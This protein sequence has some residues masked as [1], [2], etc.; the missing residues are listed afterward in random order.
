MKKFLVLYFATMSAKEQTMK[1]DP[2]QAMASMDACA[3]SE[4]KSTLVPPIPR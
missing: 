3:G 1:G 4:P 2:E